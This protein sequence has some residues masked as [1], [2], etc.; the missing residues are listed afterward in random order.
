MSPSADNDNDNNND[1]TK[2]A[3]GPGGAAPG[4]ENPAPHLPKRFYKD[5]G[6]EPRDGG[7]AILLDGRPVRT[8]HKNHLQV[9]TAALAEAIGDEWRAQGEYIDPATMH[10]TRL[11]NTAIDAVSAK[12][13]EVAN[14]IVAFA[15]SDLLC[16]RAEGPRDLVHR[17]A[18]AWDPVLRWVGERI[19]A[20]FTIVEGIM[21]VSQPAETLSAVAAAIAPLDAFRLSAL[22][23]MTTL[24]GSAV[25]ALARL[26]GRLS[27]DQAWTAAHV[28]EDWQIAQWGE[29]AE[30]A[31]RRKRRHAEF[32]AASR[33]LDL[34]GPAELPV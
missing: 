3:A 26:M 5:V 1:G 30:A 23:V 10:L 27:A 6:V 16:Y 14:E 25:L 22:H 7:F 21:P 12:M 34:L 29:D 15:G 33:L 17:Q 19:G 32:S 31:A 18:A 24:A 28:D 13:P 20:T 4:R 11:A 2:P 9:P 8:P